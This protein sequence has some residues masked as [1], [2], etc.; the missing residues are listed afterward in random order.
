ML[1]IEADDQVT[2]IRLIFPFLF[3]HPSFMLTFVTEAVNLVCWLIIYRL[4]EH[5]RIFKRTIFL[6]VNIKIQILLAQMKG[7][8]WIGRVRKKIK[9]N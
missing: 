6:S 5:K 9:V 8:T 1:S 3:V 2:H 4:V 7:K